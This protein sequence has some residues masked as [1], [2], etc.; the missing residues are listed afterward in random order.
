MDETLL[1]EFYHTY[2]KRHEGQ[3]NVAF[4][5]IV[6]AR[7]KYYPTMDK[8]GGAKLL[9]RRILR[10]EHLSEKTFLKA[11]SLLRLEASIAVDKNDRSIPPEACVYYVSANLLD[12][13]QAVYSHL[14][15]LVD[16]TKRVALSSESE[17]S[18]T[19]PHISDDFMSCLAK[20]ARRDYLKLDVDTKDTEKLD[21]LRMLMNQHNIDVTYTVETRGG[22]H[23]LLAVGQNMAPLINL[24]KKVTSELGGAQY[25]WLT[26]ES[27]SKNPLLAVPGTG[28]PRVASLC[29]QP[30]FIGKHIHRLYQGGHNK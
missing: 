24:S 14:Q 26:V 20:S 9:G 18:L 10:A 15:S 5:F 7:K 12:E 22:Y 25:S 4:M 16:F 23:V 6:M 13:R 2:L 29:G 19:V 27:P 17:T 21:E 3:V 1:M 30:I 28:R 11:L 8:K